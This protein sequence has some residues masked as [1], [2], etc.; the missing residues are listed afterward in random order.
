MNYSV[1][2]H[3]FGK[4]DKAEL[5]DLVLGMYRESFK[6]YR[7]D[8]GLLDY[9]KWFKDLQVDYILEVFLANINYTTLLCENILEQTKG[10]P[11]SSDE[12]YMPD[13]D[14]GYLLS[15]DCTSVLEFASGN[16]E[17]V[18][19]S[20]STELFFA[21][22][23]YFNISNSANRFGW[24][25]VN[26]RLASVL[27]QLIKINPKLGDVLNEWAQDIDG[28]DEDDFEDDELPPQLHW[29]HD[30]VSGVRASTESSSD[31]DYL[32]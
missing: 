11:R 15:Q 26:K 14:L 22:I 17:F 24:F 9:K 31:A 4:A 8:F 1:D 27:V 28:L 30:F 12:E 6:N 16:E 21:F 7:G 13:Y 20:L 19:D 10:E 3:T 18:R 2:V 32:S 23:Q 25:D 29:K 5:L